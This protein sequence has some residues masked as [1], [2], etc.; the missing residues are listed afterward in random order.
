MDHPRPWLKYVAADDLDSSAG[1]V[2]S[3]NF[4]AM[5]VYGTD[6][7]Q[8]GSI[9]GFIVDNSTGRPYYVVVDAGGWFKSKYFLVP[10]GHVAHD[11]AENRMVADLTR[12]RVHNFPGFDRDEF[13]KLSEADLNRME[14]Q[15]VAACCPTETIDRSASVSRYERWTHYQSPSWWDADFYRPDRADN[16]MKGM[17]APEA[18]GR[19]SQGDRQ[20]TAP[21]KGFT[22][23]VD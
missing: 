11:R 15:M 5:K 9:D 13:E 3:V 4:A 17:G 14:E 23:N 16:A 20:A 2:D 7:D 19:R 1:D 8:L 22:K 12:E 6:R 21:D 10:I 18:G